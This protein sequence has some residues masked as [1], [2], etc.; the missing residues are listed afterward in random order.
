M[1]DFF[2]IIYII[3]IYAAHEPTP[4][5]FVFYRPFLLKDLLD[6]FLFL[7]SVRLLLFR[8]GGFIGGVVFSC[9]CK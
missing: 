1:C 6:I 2:F 9:L 3:Y 7:L 4:S 5:A 8:K